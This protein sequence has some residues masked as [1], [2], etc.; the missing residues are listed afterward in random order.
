M[1]NEN[2]DFNQFIKSAIAEELAK[3][4]GGGSPATTDGQPLKL[5]LGGQTFEYKNLQELE[6]AMNTFA[7]G[8]AQ[9][10]NELQQVVSAPPPQNTQ[11]STVTDDTPVWS[12]QTFIETMSKSPKD[13]FQYALNQL[14]FD[15]KSEDPA[16]DL[17]TFL[18]DNEKN[19]R[20]LGVYQ[21][22]ESHPEYVGTPQAAQIID[23]VR[24]QMNMPYDAQ[25]LEAAYLM[26]M[27]KGLLPNYYQMA[28]M[29]QQ[30]LQQ[31]QQNGGQQQQQFQQPP[32]FNPFAGGGNL[33]AFNQN[34][35]L[36]APP[37]MGRSSGAPGLDMNVEDLS[38]DQLESILKKAGQLPS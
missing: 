19:K 31:Q 30:Q 36:Q 3:Q 5:N 22:K 27:N 37:M 4:N 35:Y 9:K 20:V 15:G 8:A 32:P 25:G 34:P 11:G 23:K 13:G 1:A 33:N 17:R 24:E 21:F 18:E 7:T 28:Q 16:A 12:D 29:A 38:V 2:E 14:L 10:I 6:Q 26:A